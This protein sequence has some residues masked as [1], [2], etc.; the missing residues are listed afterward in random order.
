MST[1]PSLRGDRQCPHG[2]TARHKCPTCDREDDQKEIDRL[3]AALRDIISA[4]ECRSEL[5]TNADDCAGNLA[6][7]AR[8]ALKDMP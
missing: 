5:F 6:D 7:R 1:K 8:K 2:H 4:Y 3:S